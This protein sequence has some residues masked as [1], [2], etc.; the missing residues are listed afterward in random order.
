MKK[1][2]VGLLGLWLVSAAVVADT[3]VLKDGH[4]DTHTVVKGDTLWDISARFLRDP[5]LWTDIWDVNPEIENPHLI[6]PGDVIRLVWRDGQPRLT[7]QRGLGSNTVKLGPQVRI[8]PIDTAIPAIPLEKIGAW[9]RRS[10]IVSGRDLEAAPYVVAAEDA[11]ILGGAGDAVYLR[12]DIDAETRAYGLYR[13]GD[14]YRD[15]DTGEVLGVEARMTAAGSITA[16]EG[17]IATL[18]LNESHEEVRI[19]DRGLV[20]A[21]ESLRAMFMPSQPAADFAGR[22]IASEA[23][24]HAVGT[25]S[26]VVL[27]KGERDGLQVGNVLAVYNRGATIKDMI[28]KRN[29]KLPDT[30]AGLL[31]VVRTFEKAS[32]GII[33]VSNA[34]MS[35]GDVLK[36]P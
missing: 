32:Y 12:G 7:V 8:E 21:E 33:L 14:T 19:G 13:R 17:D 36:A 2:L 29:V 6:F 3:V 4:P 28:S 16:S 22:I 35:V 23:G 5:W 34:P 20:F 26:V 18:Q 27:S 31:M 11:R 1:M 10:R 9:L 15:P 25:Y 30:R 24:V